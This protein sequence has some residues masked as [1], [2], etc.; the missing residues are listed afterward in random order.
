MPK[1]L[2]KK[3]HKVNGAKDVGRGTIYGN[4]F[5]HLTYGSAPIQGL[6]TIEDAVRAHELWLLLSW[7]TDGFTENSRELEQITGKTWS[8]VVRLC[9]YAP[10]ISEVYKLRGQDLVCWCVDE[11]GNGPCH[12]R[13]LMKFANKE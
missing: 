3:L 13:T 10:K 6:A 2:N 12:A 8:E 1:I 7:Y 4:K 11:N 5:S 9:G